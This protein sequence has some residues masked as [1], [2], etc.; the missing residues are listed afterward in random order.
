[1]RKEDS[2]GPAL[3]CGASMIECIFGTAGSWDCVGVPYCG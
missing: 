3:I 1:M 2:V